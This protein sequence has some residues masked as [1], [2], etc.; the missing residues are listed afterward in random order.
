MVGLAAPGLETTPLAMGTGQPGGPVAAPGIVAVTIASRG[1]F[2]RF[3]VG[4]QILHRLAS[5]ME[6]H[7]GFPGY[8][9]VVSALVFYP[10]SALLPAAIAGAWAR[11]K[12]DPD[13]GYLLGWTIGPLILLE[14]FRTKL[15]HYYLPAFPACALLVPGWSSRSRPRA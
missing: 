5:D 15:I 13:L 1:E 7:G 4:N 12:S 3:A 11:R 8:Y 14:C 9:P 6:A 10:W 2:L